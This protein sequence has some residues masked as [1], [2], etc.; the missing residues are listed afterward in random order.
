[1]LV[2][3]TKFMYY[4]HRLICCSLLIQDAL[5]KEL[6]DCWSCVLQPVLVFLITLFQS[7]LHLNSYLYLRDLTFFKFISVSGREQRSTKI[8]CQE[9][10]SVSYHFSVYT[11]Y[12]SPQM[13]SFFPCCLVNVSFENQDGG[14]LHNR[15]IIFLVVNCL[16]K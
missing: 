1:M 9:Q 15:C 10:K 8:K 3:H 6:I 13:C 2:A 11:V 16:Y 14:M 12:V 4:M 5:P 7:P